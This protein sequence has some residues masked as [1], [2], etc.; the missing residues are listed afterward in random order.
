M[1][2][3]LF[4]YESVVNRL[5]PLLTVFLFFCCI[6]FAKLTVYYVRILTFNS[7]TSPENHHFMSRDL[8][9]MVTRGIP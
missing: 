1:I 3:P 4:Y 5:K 6:L 9:Y 2:I 8:V 7:I